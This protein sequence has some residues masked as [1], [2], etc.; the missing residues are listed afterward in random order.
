MYNIMSWKSDDDIAAIAALIAQ[1]KV[2]L[3][4]SDTVLGLLAAANNLGHTALDHVK[5]RNE[6]PYLMLAVS[7]EQALNMVGLFK[8][9]QMESFD[10][11]KTNGVIQRLME[12]FWPGPMTLVLPAQSNFGSPT[13]AVRVPRHEGLLKLLAITGPLYST[14]ANI[15]GQPIPERLE[16][17]DPAIISAVAAIINGDGK[18]YPV[19]PST[20]VD[21]SGDEI[22]ILR[23]GAIKKDAIERLLRS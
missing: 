19:I 18:H 21:C 22:K 13:I 15:S 6:K 2:V 20:I 9:T 1:N 14:S 5:Q 8:S 17:V 7:Q 12:H 10:K 23:E 3:G 4:S 11:L 16:D